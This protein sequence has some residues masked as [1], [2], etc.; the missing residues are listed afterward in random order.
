MKAL[1][2]RCTLG[3]TAPELVIPTKIKVSLITS[4][5]FDLS[6]LTGVTLSFWHIYDIEPGWDYAYVEYS[7]DGGSS[8]SVAA[9]YSEYQQ[10][11]WS[12]ETIPLPQLDL[13]TTARIRFRFFSDQSINADGWHIDDIHLY[14]SGPACIT[15]SAPRAGFSSSSPALAG[16]PV[17]FT[18]HTEGTHPL[19]YSWDFGDELG[20]SSYSDP[21][22]TYAASGTYTVT[23]TIT[24]SLGS[25]TVTHPLVVETCTPVAAVT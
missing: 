4:P 6:N 17:R 10:L 2:A 14:G 1:T 19:S 11:V 16:Q 15:P 22:Y 3:P 24:N 5:V 9:S 12:Q 8:W 13:T 20:A 23:L 18:D 21:I 7:V 25:D